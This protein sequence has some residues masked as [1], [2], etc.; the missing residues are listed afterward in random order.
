MKSTYWHLRTTWGKERKEKERKGKGKK[1]K[2]N[3]ITFGSREEKEGILNTSIHS[4]HP[5]SS[6]PST[7][8]NN[9]NNNNNNN[10]IIIIIIII[11]N[12]NHIYLFFLFLFPFSFGIS[13]LE[14]LWSTFNTLAFCSLLTHNSLAI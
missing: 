14:P 8:T 12:Q 3:F 11:I 13:P 5:S 9:N 4:I 7:T 6:S 1:R 10:I 2:G